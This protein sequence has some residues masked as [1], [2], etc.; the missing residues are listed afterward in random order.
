M[1][2][3]DDLHDAREFGKALGALVVGCGA[4]AGLVWLTVFVLES[5]WGP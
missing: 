4:F 2:K 5:I 3:S 1:G